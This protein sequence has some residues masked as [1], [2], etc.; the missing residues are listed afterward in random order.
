MHLGKKTHKHSIPWCRVL[1]GTT[2][3]DNRTD[4]F[5]L[6]VVELSLMGDEESG[7]KYER[8]M[9]V[10]GGHRGVITRL[11]KEADELLATPTPTEESKSRLN[12]ICKQLQLKHEVLSGLDTQTL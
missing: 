1:I 8:L 10:R 4:L 5:L 11:I 12:V 7:A 9:A 6:F 2:K 3:G